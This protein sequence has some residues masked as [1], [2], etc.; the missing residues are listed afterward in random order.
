MTNEELA[1]LWAHQFA[2][3]FS[4]QVTGMPKAQMARLLED[5]QSLSVCLA[6]SV[7]GSS[8]ELGR[9]P[10]TLDE[11]LDFIQA[12]V[13]QKIKKASGLGLHPA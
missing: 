3:E 12:S 7:G 9:T 1:M 8:F 13:L 5:R 10:Q 11:W 4:G 6:P 2:E